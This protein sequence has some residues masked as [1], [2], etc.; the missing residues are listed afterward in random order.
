MLSKD[1][2][3]NIEKHGLVRIRIDITTMEY[4]EKNKVGSA[5]DEPNNNPFLPPP[6]GRLHFSLNPCEMYKQLIGPEMRR[7]IA[8]WCC[9]TIS[10]VLCVMI[11][12]YL[13]PIVLGGLITKWI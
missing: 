5:R 1:K 2:E 7:K 10:S 8:I 12:Y 4:A 11:L 6:I 13:V 9:I 3:G